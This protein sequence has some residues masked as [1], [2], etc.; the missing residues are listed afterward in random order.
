MKPC[1]VVV[2]LVAEARLARRWGLPV[3]IGGGD[4]AGAARAAERLAPEVSGLISFGLAGGLDPALRPGAVIVPR[5]VVDGDESWLSDPALNLRLGGPTGHVL[6]GGG[7]VLA[8]VEAKRA[9]YAAGAH[10]VD[11]ESAAVARTAAR[12]GLPFAALR[13]ICDDADR[14]L[15]H[16]ALAALDGAG[17]IG[18]L[19]VIAAV[20]AHPG[21]LPALFA[22]GRD[23]ARA[24]RALVGRI[25][26]SPG[27]I[28]K[29]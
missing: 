7:Q 17:R 27:L 14:A 11:L 12:H 28:P 6:R 10:A 23:A 13:A 25:R 20:L 29:P 9:A 18:L 16:A 8:T 4:A 26:S 2:G 1:G 24:R 22:L 3:A 15:P 21:E 5:L 19:R